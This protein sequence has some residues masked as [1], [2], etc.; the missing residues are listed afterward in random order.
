MRKWLHQR[1]IGTADVH[2]EYADV[3]ALGWVSHLRTVLAGVAL[4]LGMIDIDLSTLERA[5]PRILTQKAARV[6]F[7]KGFDQGNRISKHL[8]QPVEEVVIPACT[9]ELASQGAF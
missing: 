8:Q 4:K 1:S 5:E 9:L 3:Y 7:E 2:G 6:A